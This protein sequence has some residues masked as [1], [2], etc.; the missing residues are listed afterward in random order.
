DLCN[1]EINYDKEDQYQNLVNQIELQIEVENIGT[2]AFEVSRL[3]LDKSNELDK[4]ID[5]NK[6]TNIPLATFPNLRYIINQ[7]PISQK[8]FEEVDS[9]FTLEGFLHSKVLI[10]I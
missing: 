9:L 8:Q 6:N 3:L 2:A 1:L 5:E 7:K 4:F 10:D